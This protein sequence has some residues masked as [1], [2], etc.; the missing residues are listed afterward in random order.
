VQSALEVP[1]GSIGLLQ[2][3]QRYAAIA[4]R[5]SVIGRQRQGST[6]LGK[7]FIRRSRTQ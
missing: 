7:R 4:Q 2:E 3:Q 5:L 1:T 6:E